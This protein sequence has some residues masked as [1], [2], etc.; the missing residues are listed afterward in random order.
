MNRLRTHMTYDD[1][2]HERNLILITIVL[3]NLTILISCNN[4]S[5]NRQKA[6]TTVSQDTS[7]VSHIKKTN[8]KEDTA[9]IVGYWFTPH[10]AKV[11][12][13][14]YNDGHFEFNDYN[15]KLEAYERLTG[16][17]KLNDSLLVLQY[18]DRPQ[19]TFKFYKDSDDN[20]YIKK[21]GYYFAKGDSQ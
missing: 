7:S 4:P 8:S 16:K 3:F 12:I 17:Y 2:S 1:F 9:R 5:E 11:N 13:R 6:N 19:Q 15:L 14:F 20:Y 18:D 10:S 21:N